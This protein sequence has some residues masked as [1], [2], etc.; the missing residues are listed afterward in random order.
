L[1]REAALLAAHGRGDLAQLGAGGAGAAGRPLFAGRVDQG[2]EVTGGP[3]VLL[4]GGGDPLLRPPLV[5]CDTG[6]LGGSAGGGAGRPRRPACAPRRRRRS[7]A[8]S[9]T[10]HVRH[11]R[12][13][14]G[15]GRGCGPAR[16]TSP[17]PASRPWSRTSPAGSP[18]H[19]SRRPW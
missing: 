18:S 5:T 19:A 2:A 14:R 4:G 7:A 17:A 15:H 6:A 12:S 3:R 10:C 13:R 16:S 11:G 9:P 1:G 8:A